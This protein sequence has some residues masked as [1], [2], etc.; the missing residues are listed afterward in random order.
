MQCSKFAFTPI[1]KENLLEPRHHPCLSLGPID[2]RT[3]P[4]QLRGETHQGYM[5][6]YDTP[7]FYCTPLVFRTS[8]Y[9]VSSHCIHLSHS[10]YLPKSISSRCRWFLMLPLEEWWAAS[11]QLQSQLG[12]V[13][14]K[15]G[16]R[17]SVGR[18]AW[19]DL[20]NDHPHTYPVPR[21]CVIFSLSEYYRT[22]FAI[23]QG[24]HSAVCCDGCYTWSNLRCN[25]HPAFF[26]HVKFKAWKVIMWISLEC[27][28]SSKKKDNN[29]AKGGDCGE[30]E[31]GFFYLQSFL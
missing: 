14:G 21:R 28:K 15:N 4:L 3:H 12:G 29:N 23:I 17:K 20:S 1:N 25:F 31:R 19:G 6:G 5:P 13:P 30:E 2:H 26:P 10:T 24:I 11:N 7:L 22:M 18:P 8:L 16:E 9:Y 27:S